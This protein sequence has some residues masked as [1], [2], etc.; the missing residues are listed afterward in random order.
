[1]ID[2]GSQAAV[3]PHVDYQNYLNGSGYGYLPFDTPDVPV[4]CTVARET[5]MAARSQESGARSP[6]GARYCF[7]TTRYLL[8]TVHS[9]LVCI[10]GIDLCT[11]SDAAPRPQPVWPGENL[12]RLLRGRL[13]AARWPLAGQPH[14]SGWMDCI[15]ARPLQGCPFQA[16]EGSVG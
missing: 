11:E 6:Q 3:T 7:Y 8:C 1:M 16:A 4:P 13:L 9:A 14:A 12:C 5:K 15:P 10:Y 2:P